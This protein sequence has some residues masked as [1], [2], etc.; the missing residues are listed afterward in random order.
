MIWSNQT[1][2]L[3]M[4]WLLELS[5]KVFVLWWVQIDWIDPIIIQLEPLSD[6][7]KRTNPVLRP[8]SFSMAIMVEPIKPYKS[9]PELAYTT[10]A[11]TTNYCS[12]ELFFFDRHAFAWVFSNYRNF[13]FSFQ[14]FLLLVVVTWSWFFLNLQVFC[15]T[16][17]F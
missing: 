9:V 8:L 5:L 12:I 14:D 6:F 3:V 4:T 13:F 11:Q 16:L 1:S 2:T 7:K 10:I 15:Q 17:Q